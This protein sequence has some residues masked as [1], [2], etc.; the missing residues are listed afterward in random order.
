MSLRSLCLLIPIALACAST[1]PP[2]QPAGPAPPP[3]VSAPVATPA[4]TEPAPPRPEP[5]AA[6]ALPWVWYHSFPPRLADAFSQ[7]GTSPIAFDHRVGDPRRYTARRDDQGIE[8]ALAR[9]P[10][11]GAKGE[12]V[13]VWSRRVTPTTTAAEGAPVVQATMGAFD[14]VVVALRIPGGYERHAFT[15]AGTPV[16]SAV[17][18]DPPGFDPEGAALQLGGTA[19]RPAV[20]V[21]GTDV[22][23]LDELDPTTGQ[24]IARASFGP[25]VLHDRFP[26]PADGP[27]G[28]RFGH[29]WPA[30]DGGCYEA[31][32]RG[33]ALELRATDHARE[34][35]WRTTLEP[36]G[37][38]WWN[39]AIVLEQ[40]E[41]VVVVVY[42]ASSSGAAVH[43]LD[44]E[45]GTIAF[46]TSP[47][48]VGNIGHSMYANDVGL[49]L[50]DEGHVRIHGRESG[51]DYL[52]VLDAAA[53][54]RLGHEVWRR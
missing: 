19:E 26:W 33:E 22:A 12:P 46:S 40:G 13:P 30:R 47:G 24:P 37:A 6:S 1:E 5:L 28:R 18:L 34:E 48:G 27:K 54:R 39:Q 4:P 16:A 43:G 25:E 17:V 31:R 11:P 53:G 41:R 3:A 36:H 15:D 2:P 14:Q 38:P 9:L 51:G 29:C 20:F 35:R 32:R 8:L 49:S 45:R 42:N 52:G 10:E 23:Y 50:D 7:V 44:R 21:R